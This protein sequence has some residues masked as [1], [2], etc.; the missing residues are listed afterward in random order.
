MGA[1]RCESGDCR[2]LF[3]GPSRSPYV[4]N[5]DAGEVGSARPPPD[6]G[7]EEL[8]AVA[9]WYVWWERRQANRSE[10]V[11]APVHS[12]QAILALCPNYGRAKK[13]AEGI[14]RGGWKKPP[15]NYVKLNAD[16][17]FDDDDESGAT[18][19]IRPDDHGDFISARNCVIPYID[20]AAMAEAR[21]LRD[22]LVLAG[23]VGCTRFMV[24]SG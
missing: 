8:L 10:P 21:A 19:A 17:G 1:L 18:G 5:Y 12:A 16:A 6:I 22:G 15:Q 23:Q 11:Q 13:R 3:V 2:S 24:N 4:G 9:S 20:S 14:R 7:W